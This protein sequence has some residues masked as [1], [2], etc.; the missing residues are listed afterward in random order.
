MSDDKLSFDNP[1]ELRAQGKEEAS[2]FSMR[3]DLM[4]DIRDMI[5]ER[6][7]TQSQAAELIGITQSRVSEIVNGKFRKFTVDALMEYVRALG[8]DTVI[9]IQSPTFSTE[10]RYPKREA[11]PDLVPA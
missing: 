3:V 9:T 6:G 4:L 11:E 5:Q 10:H 7:L 1:L 8:A 2:D